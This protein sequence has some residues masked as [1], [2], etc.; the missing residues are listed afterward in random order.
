ME[1]VKDYAKLSH[2]CDE[3]ILQ[4]YLEVKDIMYKLEDALK[5]DE[6]LLAVS[7][8]QLGI[9]ARAFA[10][11]FED[12]IQ[13]YFNPM[14]SYFSKESYLSRERCIYND[15]EYLVIRNKSIELTFQTKNGTIKKNIFKEPVSALVQAMV[16]SL[17]G[18][19]ASDYGLEIIPEFDEA[20]EEERQEVITMYIDQ[21]KAKNEEMQ[22][23]IKNDEHLS[24]L[25]EEINHYSNIVLQ[26]GEL[27]VT[28]PTKLNRQQ[29]RLHKKITKQIDKLRAKEEKEEETDANEQAMKILQGHIDNETNN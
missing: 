14:I 13:F 19:V 23:E 10:L 9:N 21:L 18:V 5:E 4:N 11:K 12:G 7:T 3:T 22:E 25:N 8:N 20:T 26:E 16:D 24:K 17:E 1:L 2:R 27:P 28:E 29:K 6:N 15:K